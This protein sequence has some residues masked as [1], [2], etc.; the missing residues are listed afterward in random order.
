[1]PDLSGQWESASVPPDKK[2]FV[3]QRMEIRQQDDRIEIVNGKNNT[4]FAGI[5]VFK[6]VVKN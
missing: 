2:V 3:E 6:G 1:M 4:G 5:I